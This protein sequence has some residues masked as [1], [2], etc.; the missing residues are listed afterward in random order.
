[1]LFKLLIP[2]GEGAKT[3]KM[4][5]VTSAKLPRPAI[6]PYLHPCRQLRPAL[7]Y[8]HTSMYSSVAKSDFLV[9]KMLF[10]VRPVSPVVNP[11][12]CLYVS[13]IFSVNLILN[14]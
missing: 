8:L 13:V 3:K 9:K 5:S 4:F 11:G 10:P 14:K 12:F 2:L 1:M 7:P 6:A